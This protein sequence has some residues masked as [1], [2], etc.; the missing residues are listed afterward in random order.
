MHFCCLHFGCDGA[1]ELES[2]LWCKSAFRHS[3]THGTI[4]HIVEY[5]HRL[6]GRWLIQQ[7]FGCIVMVKFNSCVYFLVWYRL[8]PERTTFYTSFVL[9]LLVKL[10]CQKAFQVSFTLIF[11]RSLFCLQALRHNPDR[12]I[13]NKLSSLVLICMRWAKTLSLH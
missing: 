4:C 9:R 2:F 8:Q 1:D 6:W 12:S 3:N 13:L 7:T 11:K 5:C 10:T